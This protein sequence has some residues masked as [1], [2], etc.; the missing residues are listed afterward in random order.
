MSNSAASSTAAAP[1]PTDGP[2]PALPADRFQP[3]ARLLSHRAKPSFV[4]RPP[5]STRS[6]LLPLNYADSSLPIDAVNPTHS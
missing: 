4:P 1:Q 3:A 5:A 2:S 6:P